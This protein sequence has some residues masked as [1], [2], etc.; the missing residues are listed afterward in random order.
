VLSRAVILSAQSPTSGSAL[1]V[2]SQIRNN[3]RDWLTPLS[4][5]SS[6]V[7]SAILVLSLLDPQGRLVLALAV[8]LLSVTA[9]SAFAW[10]FKRRL[11]A[12]AQSLGSVTMVLTLCVASLFYLAGMQLSRWVQQRNNPP[13]VSTAPAAATSKSRLPSEPAA[14]A[15]DSALAELDGQAAKV[16]SHKGDVPAQTE[17]TAIQSEQE[18]Q[19]TAADFTPP[20]AAAPVKSAPAAPTAAPVPV[21]PAPQPVRAPTQT[22]AA[23]TAKTPAVSTTPVVSTPSPAPAATARSPKE[24]RA[25]E[26]RPEQRTELR[27][28]A[29]QSASNDA[30]CV[31]ITQQLSLGQSVGDND[32]AYVRRQCGK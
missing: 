20:P 1:S 27:A 8:V 31:R 25:T 2:L 6:L 11:G 21:D 26:A 32:L 12:W 30:R 24:A 17:D 9:L 7:G 10:M 22:A 15:T 19:Q 28:E 3:I 4:T 5:L 14:P 29:E 13:A 16:R 18:P 23:T